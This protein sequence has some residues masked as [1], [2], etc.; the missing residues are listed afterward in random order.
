MS[1]KN[2]KTSNKLDKMLAVDI[3]YWFSNNILTIVD[4]MTMAHS[5]ESRVP[6]TDIKVFDVARKLPKN[7]KVSDGTT[8]VA[9]RNAAKK[10]IPNDAY[11]KKKLGFPV[12]IRE[13]IREDDFYNEI[14]KLL[15]NTDIS[16]ELFNTDY[17]IKILDEH[18][19]RKKDNY[20]KIWA[21]YSFLK[22]YDEYFVKR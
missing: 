8:K 6:F 22:W 21:V 12:P 10:V 9:L 14:K 11:K 1:I 2:I 17:L 19:D 20:R 5:I 18:H 15:F 7:Y 4:K 16:K 3:R 13:W